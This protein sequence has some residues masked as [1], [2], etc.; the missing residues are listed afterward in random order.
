MLVYFWI[1]ILIRESSVSPS[2]PISR[3]NPDGFY[4]SFT[5]LGSLVWHAICIPRVEERPS[6]AYRCMRIDHSSS[7]TLI[8]ALPLV[9]V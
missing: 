6:G 9:I 1:P 4:T 3:T 8:L 7:P 2:P 5:A